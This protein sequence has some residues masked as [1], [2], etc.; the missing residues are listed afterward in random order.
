[1]DA[2]SS[3]SVIQSRLS[4]LV[5]FNGEHAIPRRCSLLNRIS[6]PSGQINWKSI[7]KTTLKNFAETHQ[8]NAIIFKIATLSYEKNVG[9]WASKMRVKKCMHVKEFTS[10]F[11]EYDKMTISRQIF[12]E[13]KEKRR[14]KVSTLVKKCH[15]LFNVLGKNEFASETIKAGLSRKWRSSLKR[16]AAAST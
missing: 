15:R 6:H 16:R 3:H 5:D 8:N 7:E 11:L 14:L 10:K 13:K 4:A 2:P 9:F 1:M 12:E